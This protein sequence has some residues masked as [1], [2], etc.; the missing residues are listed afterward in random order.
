[1]TAQV[2]EIAPTPASATRQPPW[3]ASAPAAMRPVRPPIEF[4]AMNSPIARPSDPRS[5][6]SARYA[7]ATAGTPASAKPCSTRIATSTGSDGASVVASP[8][9]DAASALTVIT[10]RRPN[11]SDSELTG[12]TAIASAN[13]AADI[14]RLAVAGPVAN[15]PAICGSS[16]CGAYSSANVASAAANSPSRTRRIPGSVCRSLRATATGSAAAAPRRAM[17]SSTPITLSLSGSY[18][19][20]MICCIYHAYMHDEEVAAGL[21][22][23]APRLRQFV[24]VAHEEHLTRAADLLGVPQPTLSRSIARLEAELGVPLFARPG[25]SIKLTRHGRLLLDGAERAVATLTAH[26]QLLADEADPAGGRVALGFLH[27]LGTEAVPRMLRDFR[28]GNPGVRFALVQG[29]ADVLLTRLRAGEV[30]LCLTAPLPDEPGMVARALDSQRID[31]IVPAG[32]RLARRRGVRLAEAAGEDFI[33]LKRGYGLR[34]ITDELCRAAGFEPRIAFEGE[35]AATCQGLVGAG[36]GVSLLP[37]TLTAA[38]D[39][40]VVAVRITAPRA[41]RT[42]GLVWM[43]DRPQAAPVAAFRDF[44]LGYRGNAC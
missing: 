13:V 19:Q 31:L 16:G 30:D 15:V 7:M 20:C 41:A 14:A 3:S 36:L 29:S 38:A 24:A 23:L 4:P 42:V 1:M 18:V 6:S 8:S 43:G 12:M 11:T 5:T 35:E 39:P 44:A 33:G 25:R 32:H 27:T 34:V 17:L 2:T 9:T 22:A 10:R 26:L 21:D 40:E 37:A 28:A